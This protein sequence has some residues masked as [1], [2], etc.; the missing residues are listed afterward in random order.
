MKSIHQ[1]RLALS[2]IENGRFGISNSPPVFGSRPSAEV[3][4]IDSDDSV[5]TGEL[6]VAND[7]ET[8]APKIYSQEIVGVFKQLDHAVKSRGVEALAWYV[9]FHNSAEEWGIYIPMTSVHYLA[10]RLF[11]KRR[12][13][14]SKIYQL[15]YDLLLNHERFHF[16]ADYAQTQLELLLGVPCRSMLSNQFK[17]GEYL[18][19]EEALA[20]AY[21]LRELKQVATLRQFEQIKSF[22]LGQPAGYKDAIP[23]FEDTELY[24][25]GLAEVVKS[26][27]GLTALRKNAVLSVSCI[28]WA[29]HFGNSESINW[30]ECPI[31]ILHDDGRLGLP[32]LTPKFL[33]CI[34][35]IIET[36]KFSKKFSTLAR[37]YQDSW[38]EKKLEL[39]ARPPNPKQF[40]KL[41]GKKRGLYSVRIGGGHRVHLQ[42]INRFEYWEAFEIGTHTE[43]GHD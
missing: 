31:H 30:S 39:A 3:T 10:N 21:M 8:T 37:Q 23:Y 1:I 25:H 32:P 22:V 15:A 27:A 38:Q 26:Y 6:G 13:A 42:P 14:K 2:H 9:S 35:T 40:E 16:L 33:K 24:Q 28:D 41:V 34:P 19:I 4:T 36:K 17:T 18:E 11:S 7:D 43:M 5:W 20:N 29:S 12:G